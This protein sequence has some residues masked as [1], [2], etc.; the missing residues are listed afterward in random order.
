M[1][2]NTKKKGKKSKLNVKK[3]RKYKENDEKKTSFLN[4]K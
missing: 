2:Q 4:F 1:D 3:K